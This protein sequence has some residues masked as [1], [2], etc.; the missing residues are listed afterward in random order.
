MRKTVLRLSVVAL[1]LLFTACGQST[2]SVKDNS[3]KCAKI[4]R[5]LLKVERFTQKVE[6]MSA[7]HLE[8]FATA[9]KYPQISTSNNKREMLKDAAKR[10]TKLDTEFTVLACDATE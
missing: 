5:D 3:K 10:K 8:E 2:P 7:F 6:S 1:A 4:E 9:I